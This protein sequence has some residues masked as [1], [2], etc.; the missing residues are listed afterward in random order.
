MSLKTIYLAA[1]I[2]NSDE[3]HLSRLLILLKACGKRS[4]KPVDGIIKLAKLDFLLRYPNCLV[5]VLQELDKHDLAASI[6]EEDR[7]TIEA[8]MI[9]FRFGPWDD[10][11]RRWIGLL[12]ARRLAQTY[13]DGRTVKVL[14]TDSGLE[15]AESLGKRSEFKDLAA[16]SKMISDCVGTYSATNLKNFVYKVFPEITTMKWGEEIAI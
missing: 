2:E 13:L 15:L 3:F 4:N 16:R 5:R 12:V 11:Y 6:S 7:N 1:E 14:L 9:R 8:R 10:R